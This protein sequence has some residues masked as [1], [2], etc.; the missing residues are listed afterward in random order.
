MQGNQLEKR[1]KTIESY[2]LVNM[3]KEE[4]KKVRAQ[5]LELISLD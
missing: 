5:L 1:S 2:R 4:L 3:T